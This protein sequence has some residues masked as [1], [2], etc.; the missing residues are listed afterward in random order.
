M[1]ERERGRKGGREDEGREKGGR[2]GERREGGGK[3][4]RKKG[5]EIKNLLLLFLGTPC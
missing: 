1:R 4:I 5:R 3:V 2:E